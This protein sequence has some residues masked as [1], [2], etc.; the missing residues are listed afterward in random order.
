MT[1]MRRSR[2]RER[3]AVRRGLSRFEVRLRS[4]CPGI[5]FTA[6]I[7]ATVHTEPPYPGSAEEITGAVRSTLRK[8]AGEVAK[9]CDPVDLAAA[10]DVCSQHLAR[11]RRLP[12]DPPVTFTAEL[13]LDLLADDRAAVAELL[14]AQRQQAVADVLR[15]QR[16]D[17]LAVEL[18]DPAALW[19]RWIERGDVDLSQLKTHAD[20]VRSVAELFA[21]RRPEGER[22][23]EHEAV[24]VLREFLT[25]FP[26]H[27][28]KQMLYTLLAAGMDSAQRPH[29]AA[30]A[31]ALSNGRAPAR[32]EGE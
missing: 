2:H 6:R 16:T 9:G 11:L 19:V 27:S 28:Q 26:D 14:T 17:A 22:T 24:E 21:R 20:D 30:K 1:F 13:A 18:A 5:G 29:H 8:A 23:V 7:T 10:R 32:P 12:T 25:S 3:R 4:S 15:R 31:R